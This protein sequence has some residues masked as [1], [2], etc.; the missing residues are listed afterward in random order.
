MFGGLDSKGVFR[1]SLYRIELN[2]FLGT[3]K[4]KKIFNS[5]NNEA[6]SSAPSGRIGASL[7]V[8]NLTFD[9]EKLNPYVHLIFTFN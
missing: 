2:Y 6:N 7:D 4:I 8:I 3:A 9:V 5:Q 1:N